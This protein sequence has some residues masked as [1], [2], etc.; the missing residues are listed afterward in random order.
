MT[1]EPASSEPQ[2]KDHHLIEQLLRTE[3]DDWLDFKRIGNITSITKTA[4]AMANSA[5]GY[6]LVGIEDSKKAAGRDRLYGIEE[7][8][9]CQGEI[10]REFVSKVTPPLKAPTCR[11]A[12]GRWPCILR[13]GDSGHVL[14]I[15][16][17][18]S[19]VVHSIIDGGTYA[20]FHGQNRQ[21]P[22]DEITALSLRR[23]AK[24]AVD[25]PVDISVDLLNTDQWRLYA[26]ARQL[27]R[28][29]PD[30]MKH[31]GL[32]REDTE[33]GRWLPTMAAVLL[34]ADHPGG[35]LQKKCAVRVFHYKGHQIE[36]GAKPNLVHKP[37]TV[38]GPVLKQI[39]DATVTIVGE[40]TSGVQISAEG[41]KYAQKYPL[42]VIQEAITNAVLHRD[43]RLSRDVHIR[44][45]T[46]RIEIESP[47][48]LPGAI[49]TEN[50]PQMGSFPR[51]R[52]LVDHLRE[53]PEPPNLDAGEG[54]KMMF[55]T[56]KQEGFYP[57]MY[58]EDSSSTSE[59][60]VVT[61]SNEA[62][63][64]EWELVRE[65]LADHGTVCNA[66]IRRILNYGKNNVRASKLLQAWIRQG[67]IEIA[68]PK[69]GTRNRRYCFAARALKPTLSVLLASTGKEND[70]FRKFLKDKD[71]R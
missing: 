16:I 70:L 22:A 56:M 52:S 6:I 61:L 58:Q 3:E 31:L 21:L 51:N 7:K 32:L 2:A 46:N 17:P 49:T 29:L 50:I 19:N 60:V 44:V 8:P 24:S 1:M 35:L 42:R 28:K 37:V 65:Y 5:G 62:R 36:H 67:L 71:L 40:L 18:K 25:A 26:D 9:E 11:V 43:Y 45:F 15:S 33:S 23:G 63:L 10:E 4:S 68:N 57:P 34:F 13:T 55:E 69:A 48:V 39:R 27:S 30:A 53:F 64:S 47:G 54:V 20:R 66:D 59:R 38:D 12:I 41:H 14:F